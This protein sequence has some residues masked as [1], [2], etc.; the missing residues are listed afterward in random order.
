MKAKI[1]KINIIREV[2]F[3]CPHCKELQVVNVDEE[4][5]IELYCQYCSRTNIQLDLN[6]IVKIV[7]VS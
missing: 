4:V 1:V 6:P 5:Y 7:L 3:E 2:H